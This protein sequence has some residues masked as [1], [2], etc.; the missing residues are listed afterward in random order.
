MVNADRVAT[1]LIILPEVALNILSSILQF[2]VLHWG[3]KW[4]AL[5]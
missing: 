1:D 2:F 3:V 4:K 5:P